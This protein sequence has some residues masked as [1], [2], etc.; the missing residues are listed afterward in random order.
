MWS[1]EY[2][3]E[4]RIFRMDNQ[5]AGFS[6][7]VEMEDGM[8]SDLI[9]KNQVAF[10]YSKKTNETKQ[11][12]TV[13]CVDTLIHNLNI[14]ILMPNN[15]YIKHEVSLTPHISQSLYNFANMYQHHKAIPDFSF[16]TIL[17]QDSR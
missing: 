14:S 8:T 16:K 2:N 13:I 7:Q 17:H 10:F 5:Q 15:N 11:V 1:F 6:F 9:N 3:S 12:K 4:S